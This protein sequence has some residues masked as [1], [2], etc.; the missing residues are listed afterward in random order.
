MAA[1]G[2]SARGHASASA[3]SDETGERTVRIRPRAPAGA[4][5]F[6]PHAALCG[7]AAVGVPCEALVVDTGHGY[8]LILAAAV[9]TAALV[10][11]WRRQDELRFAPILATAALY[12]VAVVAVHVGGGVLGD[13]DVASYGVYGSEL[14]DG[15]F[16]QTEYP[17]GAVFLF[18]LEALLGNGSAVTRTG[19]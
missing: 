9:A 15:R 1:A 5:T 19:S 11:A 6:G 16:P 7:A 12:Q 14:V 4:P 13:Q 10:Y 2:R 17:A 3:I 18:G 8:W